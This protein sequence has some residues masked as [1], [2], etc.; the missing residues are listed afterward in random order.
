H[1]DGDMYPPTRS[2]YDDFIASPFEFTRYLELRHKG[3]L[4]ACSLVDVLDHGIS[5]IYTYYDPADT[6]RS[7]GTMAILAAIGEAR[8]RNLPYLYL[9]YWIAN[10]Q[11][12]RYKTRFKPIEILNDGNWQPHS[13]H[14]GDESTKNSG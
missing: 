7:L 1:S 10:C 13:E 9:G 4:I 2:Q 5:A 11:K 6:R 14:S 12:M 3:R 8:S